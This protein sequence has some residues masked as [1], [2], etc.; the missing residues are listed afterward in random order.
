MNKL[1]KSNSFN[2]IQDKNVFCNQMQNCNKKI[3]LKY[4]LLEEHVSILECHHRSFQLNVRVPSIRMQDVPKNKYPLIVD[5][6]L[7]Y[8]VDSFE[9]IVQHF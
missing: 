8:S 2:M 6:V 3:R 1:K 5:E 4:E 9:L 7:T